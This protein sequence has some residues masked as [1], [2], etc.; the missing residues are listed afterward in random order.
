MSARLWR[1]HAKRPS[2]DQI[3]PVAA[4]PG[5]SDTRVL[6]RVDSDRLYRRQESFEDTRYLP[7]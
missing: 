2:S 4:L 1:A 5:Q 7:M 3:R 6:T